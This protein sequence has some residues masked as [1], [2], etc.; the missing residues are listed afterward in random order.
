MAPQ[1]HCSSDTVIRAVFVPEVGQSRISPGVQSQKPGDGS[2][3]QQQ[4]GHS[5]KLGELHEG[6]L[7]WA[8]STE[9]AKPPASLLENALL[10][11]P[12]QL[13][14]PSIT[15]FWQP[16]K[17]GQSV[18]CLWSSHSLQ[19]EAAAHHQIPPSTFLQIT[20]RQQP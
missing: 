10:C 12:R 20:W 5:G 11:C 3:C 15:T 4:G 17:H 1:K 16:Q 14:N 8:V 18:R 9:L 19:P 6:T 7:G 13:S 2:K